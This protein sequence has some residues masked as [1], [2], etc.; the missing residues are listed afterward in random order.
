LTDG[1]VRQHQNEPDWRRRRG[2]LPCATPERALGLTGGSPMA[3][4]LVVDDH[5]DLADLLARTLRAMGHAAD[6][7]VDGAAAV[8]YVRA[9]PP[10]LVLLDV[11]MPGTDGFQVLATLQGDPATAGVPVVMYSAVADRSARDAALRLG[12]RAYLVKSTAT[13]ADIEAAVAQHAA[14]AAG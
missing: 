12:A 5:E 1:K 9:S 11:M 6:A 3:T 13:L 10:E 7:V 2:T 14:P 4:V 8:E